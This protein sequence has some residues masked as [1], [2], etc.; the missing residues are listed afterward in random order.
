MN[1]IKKIKKDRVGKAVKILKGYCDKHSEC[2]D[3]RFADE[4]GYCQFEKGKIPC[5][6]SVNNA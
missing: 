4:K 6:W 5:D 2:F 3:C 1:L